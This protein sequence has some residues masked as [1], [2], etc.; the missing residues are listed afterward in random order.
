MSEATAMAIVTCGLSDELATNVEMERSTLSVRT[1]EMGGGWELHNKRAAFHKQ[2]ITQT[3]C[4][5]A[6]LTLNPKP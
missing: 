6:D 5:T 3:T 2:Q 1:Y 4:Y